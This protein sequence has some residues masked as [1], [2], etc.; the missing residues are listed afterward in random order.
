MN[1]LLL[2]IENNNI[3]FIFGGFILYRANLLPNNLSK[4]LKNIIPNSLSSSRNGGDFL[5]L[6]SNL[7]SKQSS[8]LSD[9]IGFVL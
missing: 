6:L 4:Y 8:F 3:Q 7:L 5:S 2:L 1:S 9:I